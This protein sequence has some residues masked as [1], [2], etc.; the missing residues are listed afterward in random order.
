MMNA[1]HALADFQVAP[2]L[3]YNYRLSVDRI[4]QELQQGK[5]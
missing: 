5:E 1:K 4:D 3:I 2:N